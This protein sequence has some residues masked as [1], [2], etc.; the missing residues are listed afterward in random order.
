MSNDKIENNYETEKNLY[1]KQDTQTQTLRNSASHN[2]LGNGSFVR[3]NNLKNIKLDTHDSGNNKSIFNMNTQ[4]VRFEEPGKNIM[5]INYRNQ[6]QPII[7][8]SE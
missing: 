6:N 4:R 8:F 1:N 2:I 7:L 5:L 3:S